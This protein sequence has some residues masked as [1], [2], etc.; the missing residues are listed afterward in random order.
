MLEL[1]YKISD[2]TIRRQ[3]KAVAMVWL[4]ASSS[5]GSEST[6]MESLWSR[7]HTFLSGGEPMLWL[8]GKGSRPMFEPSRKRPSSFYFQKKL[9]WKINHGKP[10]FMNLCTLT[11]VSCSF[12]VCCCI[13]E[14][15]KLP[16]TSAQTQSRT[17]M[18]CFWPLLFLFCIRSKTSAL[19]H[20]T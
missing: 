9:I 17:E 16:L 6:C 11:S 5:H 12:P 14:M 7:S 18:Y 3:W 19:K 15:G 20:T 8:C 13:P 4:S 2:F 10:P 1:N